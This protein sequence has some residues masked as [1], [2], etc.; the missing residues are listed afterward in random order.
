[1]RSQSNDWAAAILSS[2]SA[3]RMALTDFLDLLQEGLA[4]SRLGLHGSKTCACSVSSG[5][6]DGPLAVW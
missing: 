6:L 1:M 3:G 5:S 2:A 4:G